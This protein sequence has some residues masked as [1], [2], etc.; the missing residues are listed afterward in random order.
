[1]EF[2]PSCHQIAWNL[3]PGSFVQTI[4]NVCSHE[5]M[6]MSI[7]PKYTSCICPKLEGKQ[8]TFKRWK[9]KLL[10]SRII[11][12][13]TME[14]TID[15]SSNMDQSPMHFHKWKKPDPKACDSTDMKCWRRQSCGGENS[16]TAARGCSGERLS[17]KE[18]QRR[19]F[20]RW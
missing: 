11:H 13:Y 5:N 10:M 15:I 1:M 6:S 18:Q 2:L 9:D 14:Q 7:C 3:V 4:Q 8:L 17:T 16:S 19:V 12:S 20:F